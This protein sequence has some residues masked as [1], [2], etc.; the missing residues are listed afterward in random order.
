MGFDI[1][2]SDWMFSKNFKEIGLPFFLVNDW[3][4]LNK[5]SAEELNIEYKKL[6]LELNKTQFSSS[7]FWIKKILLFKSEYISYNY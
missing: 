4:D 7:D 1:R 2:K 5:L 6:S 3:S